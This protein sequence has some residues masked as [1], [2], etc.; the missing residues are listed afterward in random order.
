[1]HRKIKIKEQKSN[2]A[3][4]S[5][6]F[7]IEIEQAKLPDQQIQNNYELLTKLIG[8]SDVVISLDST[9]MNLAYKQRKPLIHKFLETIREMDLE[10]KCLK[11]TGRS[12]QSFLSVL[13]GVKDTEEQEILAYI[14]NK[15]WTDSS[16]QKSLP[17]YGARYFV[18]KNVSTGPA[19]LDDMQKML[20]DE[21]LEYFRL[22]IFN[23]IS[24]SSTG[25]FSKYLSLSELKEMLKT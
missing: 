7:T 13:F 23:S 18:T 6:R 12:N 11:V 8:T 19:V 15:I 1:M 25:I 14:P 16:L 17:F 4:D 22:I 20:D 5:P 10:Y 3:F 24:I 9:L 21:K 2:L